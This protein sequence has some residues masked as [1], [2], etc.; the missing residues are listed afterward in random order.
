MASTSGSNR[1]LR[2]RANRPRRLID[3]DVDN[4]PF[5]S[6]T[7]QSWDQPY[8]EYPQQRHTPADYLHSIQLPKLNGATLPY[9]P[10]QT[11]HAFGPIPTMTPAGNNDMHF[12]TD[13]DDPIDNDDDDATWLVAVVLTTALLV[14]LASIVRSCGQKAG[15]FPLSMHSSQGGH[16][17]MGGSGGHG[18]RGSSSR[19][20]SSGPLQ[21]PGEDEP[22]PDSTLNEDDERWA[23][24]TEAQ[25]QAYTSSRGVIKA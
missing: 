22:D 10:S 24:L 15:W 21:V 8:S 19:Y 4:D 2:K 20:H 9:Q 16:E 7:G 23:L 18:P 11:V 14:T 12:P 5:L 6:G 17:S 25:R 3:D 13:M 1:S